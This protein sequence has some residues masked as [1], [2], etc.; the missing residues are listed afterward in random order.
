ME[1]QSLLD[2]EGFMPH[3]HCYLWRP[4]I[5][6]LNVISDSIIVIAYYSIPLLLAYL[7]FKVKEELRFNWIFLLFSIFILACGTT[8]L[9]EIIN[10]WNAEYLLAGVLKAITAIASILTALAMLKI[11][12]QVIDLLKK[13]DQEL[14]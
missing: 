5:L 2:F 12:P 11:L 8:H 3:G 7:V 6:W 1:L 14:E 13:V 9:M 4:D 10:V